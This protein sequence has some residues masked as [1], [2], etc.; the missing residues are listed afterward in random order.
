MVLSFAT[1]ASVVLS[2][3]KLLHLYLATI[4]IQTVIL[5]ILGWRVF[6]QAPEM[7]L[8][9][10]LFDT[11]LARHI[12]TFSVW[13]MVVQIGNQLVFG[14]SNLVI[15]R[16]AGITAVAGYAIVARLLAQA[17]EVLYSTIDVWIPVFA[18]LKVEGVTGDLRRV[19]GDSASLATALV[20]GVCLMFGFYGPQA[21]N[22]WLRRTDLAPPEVIWLL[23]AFWS[24]ETVKH[25]SWAL[26]LATASREQ[27]RTIS[28]AYIGEGIL[29]LGLSIWLINYLGLAGVALA[30]LLACLSTSFF[31]WPVFARRQIQVSLLGYYVI[32]ARPAVCGSVAGGMAGIGAG[33]LLGNQSALTV[34]AGIAS[35]AIAYASSAWF[36]GMDSGQRQRNSERL[37]RVT[38]PWLARLR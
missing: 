8:S 30:S 7:R 31:V 18:R 15:A 2:G 1:L 9:P 35:V 33:W 3:G 25:C 11:E 23:C 16:Y 20:S 5:C 37:G 22:L 21:L 28:L 12:L 29:S 17:A 32:L 6:Q 10:A 19:F 13:I 27:M 14:A 34:M 36:I 4:A 24:V 26:L 38:R